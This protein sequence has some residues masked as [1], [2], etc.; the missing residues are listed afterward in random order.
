MYFLPFEKT[1]ENIFA[2]NSSLQ[3]LKIV[4]SYDQPDWSLPAHS[5]PDQAELM[6]VAGGKAIYTVDN[7][8]YHVGR[9]DILIFNS[10]VVHSMESDS[11]NPLDVWSCTV[12]GF[13]LPELP[14]NHVL[15]AGASP[16]YPAGG[17][18]ELFFRIFSELLYQR[19]NEKPGYYSICNALANALLVLCI[20]ISK[21]K[22][23]EQSNSSHALASEVLSY[24][25]NHYYE[26]IT[27]QS[28]SEH[29]HMST[30]RLSH[31]V[32]ETFH[33]SPISYVIDRRIRQAQWELVSTEYSIRDIAEHVGYDNV[34][35]FANLF[36]DRTGFS[37]SELRE[38][39]TRQNEKLQV[40]REKL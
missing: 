29:F 36:Q 7:Y 11:Q 16:V 38:K 40:R 19:Q 3:I 34:H 2:D 8:P 14:K 24:I 17:R 10:N 20:Q 23:D 6:Y 31:I 18:G 33:V 13:Q 15:P 27:M 35:H 12:R 9:D 25:D 30:S 4:H 1:E 39:Y 37:P 26:P 5:H 21:E 22:S 32:N 28:L